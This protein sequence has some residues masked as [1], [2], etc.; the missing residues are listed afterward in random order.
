MGGNV[1]GGSDN[2]LY[3]HI[4][5]LDKSKFEPLVLY[6][7]RGNSVIKLEAINI[8][9]LEDKF[10]G[11]KLALIYKNMGRSKSLKYTSLKKIILYY[12]FFF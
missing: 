12:N 4:T 7:E 5:N 11:I 2:S 6:R 8:F 3:Y 10:L 9:T 1:G